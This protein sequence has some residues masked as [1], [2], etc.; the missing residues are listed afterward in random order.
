MIDEYPLIGFAP[1]MPPDTKGVIVES[2]AILPTVR[3]V[4][5]GVAFEAVSTAQT[6]RYCGGA[7]LTGIDGYWTGRRIF[8][9]LTKLYEFVD[10]GAGTTTTD[11][12][13]G[14]IFNAST[15]DTWSFAQ[16]GAISLA[17]N[18]NNT[19]QQSTGTN[20]QFSAIAG[21][22]KAAIVITPSLPAAQFAMVADYNAGAGQIS[23]GIMWSALSNYA[24]WVPSIA[25][26]CGATRIIDANGPI[27]ALVPYRGGVVAFKRFSMYLGT[28]TAP[29]TPQS[30]SW[31]RISSG[32]GCIGKNA[33]CIVN[34]TLV[35]ADENGLWAYDGSYPRPLPGALQEWWSR[36]INGYAGLSLRNFVRLTWD[37]DTGKL[38]VG[39]GGPAT[40]NNHVVF[41]THAQRWTY[42]GQVTT[43]AGAGALAEL[44]H[45]DYGC[46]FDASTTT[47]YRRGLGTP[48]ASLRLGA[49]GSPYRMT[50]IRS[51]RPH[52]ATGP[53]DAATGWLSGN[54]YHGAT[55]RNVTTNVQ[56]M[57][58]AAPGRLDGII[59]DR[60][61]S[62]QMATT[63][64]NPWEMASVAV[65][66]LAREGE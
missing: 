63:A 47:L 12:S 33:A 57:S 29:N 66:E 6:G 18:K 40:A 61:V 48:A 41:N 28:Y 21:A 2:S 59:E 32:V 3:G 7:V 14:Q 5:S 65:D 31:E 51:V 22:P 8:G 55:L 13:G 43:A 50:S 45:T 4:S 9:T 20:G 10:F 62:P 19:L 15:T 26:G 1:D 34:D 49:H 37:D 23:D 24:D 46:A 36:T 39:Y 42:Y 17:V 25:S 52:F 56:P 64:G 38:W 58:F 16:F 44:F 30:W 11:I 54:L 60:Y 27:T 53:A 35:F